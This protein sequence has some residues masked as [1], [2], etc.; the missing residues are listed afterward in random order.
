MEQGQQFLEAAFPLRAF[1]T[2]TGVSGSGK[3]SLVS[4]VLVELVAGHLGQSAPQEDDEDEN[5]ALERTAV[6]TT[7]G[8]IVSGVQGVKRLVLTHISAR[9]TGARDLLT[10]LEGL[11]DD[12]VLARDLM[13]LSV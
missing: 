6:V 7:G 12:F 4:Q 3:S 9:Y 8:E 2:V 10:G 5:E 1:T 13:E 11:H